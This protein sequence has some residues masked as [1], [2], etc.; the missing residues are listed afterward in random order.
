MD[1]L[2]GKRRYGIS[3]QACQGEVHAEGITRLMNKEIAINKT[4]RDLKLFKF[5]RED[6]TEDVKFLLG[7]LWQVAWETRMHDFGEFRERKIEQYNRNFKKINEF[8][9]QLKAAKKVGYSDRAILRALQTGKRT[10]A[11]HYWKY[12]DGTT[13][14]ET[15]S[16]RI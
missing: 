15:I 16:P 7:L 6:N 4:V 11:G 1:L 12:K 14:L 8:D 13:S 3:V 10:R 2:H 9:S 5:I